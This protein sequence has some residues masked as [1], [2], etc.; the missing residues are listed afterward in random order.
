ML[1]LVSQISQKIEIYP[2]NVAQYRLWGFSY[3]LISL[4]YAHSFRLED[5]EFL[6]LKLKN[7]VKILGSMDYGSHVCT[8]S[9][10]SCNL[11]SVIR[12]LPVS[13]L[14]S[15]ISLGIFPFPHPMSQTKLS[16]VLYLNY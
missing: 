3:Y 6:S 16:K 10:S 7:T 15:G 1:P 4:C 5:L 9:L 14:L 13:F 12:S 2:C 11:Q 8:V